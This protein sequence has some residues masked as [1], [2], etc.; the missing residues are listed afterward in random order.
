MAK[1]AWRRLN[2]EV[3]TA[4]LETA[5]SLFP[6]PVQITFEGQDFVIVPFDLWKDKVKKRQQEEIEL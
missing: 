6:Q 5:A 4:S 1:A 2:G 3:P